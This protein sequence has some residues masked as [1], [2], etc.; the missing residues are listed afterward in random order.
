MA[1]IGP[2][3]QWKGHDDRRGR[4]ICVGAMEWKGQDVGERRIAYYTSLPPGHYTFT[5]AAS[6]N[7]GVWNVQESALDIFVERAFWQT[8]WFFATAAVTTILLYRSQEH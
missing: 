3:A 2:F 5:L 7:D 8:P 4:R 1:D 6:N